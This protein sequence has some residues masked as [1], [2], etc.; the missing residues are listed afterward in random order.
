MVPG[1]QAVADVPRPLLELREVLAT[2]KPRPA[3]VMTTARTD[4]SAASLSAA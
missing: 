3:P 1:A 2:Q 4:G